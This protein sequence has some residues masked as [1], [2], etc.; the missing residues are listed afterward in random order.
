[1]AFPKKISYWA[2]SHPINDPTQAT[3]LLRPEKVD[4]Y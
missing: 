3:E 1:L 2:Y 4:L